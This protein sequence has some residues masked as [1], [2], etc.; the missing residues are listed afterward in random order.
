MKRAL[1][2]MIIVA[3]GLAMTQPVLACVQQQSSQEKCC[4][5]RHESEGAASC[6][7]GNESSTDT[8][9]LSAKSTGDAQVLTLQPTQA[10]F[11]SISN[12]KDSDAKLFLERN[13]GDLHSAMPPLFMLDNAFLI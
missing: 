12:D 7:C 9:Q 5:C 6:C 8:I 2:V 11:V 4:S 13:P 3:L 10:A 1:V